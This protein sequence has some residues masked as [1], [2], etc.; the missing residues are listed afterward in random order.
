MPQGRVRKSVLGQD[1]GRK[2][3]KVQ[4]STPTHQAY[5]PTPDFLGLGGMKL[6]K[7]PLYM[8]DPIRVLSWHLPLMCEDQG[9]PWASA[10]NK[11]TPVV[12]DHL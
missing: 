10:N 6:A 2:V 9:D 1:S 4:V 7:G 3:L 8:T 11:P 12:M 5:L